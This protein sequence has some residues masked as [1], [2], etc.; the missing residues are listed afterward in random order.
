MSAPGDDESKSA[1]AGGTC[2]C[3]GADA[4]AASEFL[5]KARQVE[6]L[7]DESHLGV[8]LI[9]CAGCRQIFLRIFTELIDWSAG[10]DS[11]AWVSVPI[12]ARE[13]EQLRANRDW[14]AFV[15]AVPADR[16]FLARVLPRGGGGGS[17]WG[18]GG[19]PIFPHD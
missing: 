12:D 2:T 4:T 15:G 18:I 3:L 10:D 5:R 1:A 6:E 17:S 9:Q 19:V 16:R 14:A 7:V 8:S 11:Q 13:A